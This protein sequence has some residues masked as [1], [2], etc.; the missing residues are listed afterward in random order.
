MSKKIYQFAVIALFSLIFFLA[1]PVFAADDAVKDVRFLSL[2]DIHF[3]PFIA[4]HTEN[5]SPCPLIQKLQQAPASKWADIFATY[6]ATHPEHRQDSN[7]SLFKSALV[8]ARQAADQEQARFVIILGDFLGH[9]FGTYYKKYAS[10]K[11]SAGKHAFIEKTMQ[12]ISLEINNTFHGM[13]IYPVVGNN[14]SYTGDYSSIVNGEFFHNTAEDWSDF[15]KS[16]KN[17]AAFLQQFPKAGYYSVTLSQQ[18]NLRFIFMNTVLFSS[19]ARG[20]GVD[21]AAQQ[22]LAWL[23]DELNAAHQNKQKVYIAMHIPPG[24]DVYTTLKT[25]LL[26]LVQFWKPEYVERYE[27]LL[28]QHADDVYA[29]FSG[30]LHSDWFQVLTFSDSEAEIPVTG[31]PSISPLFGNNPG[32]K[33]YS[34]SPTTLRL[35]DFVTYYYPIDRSASWGMEYDFN[36]I[37]QPNCQDCPAVRGMQ[38]LQRSGGLSDFFKLFYSTGTTSQPIATQW[39]PYYWCAI[40]NT[41]E[42]TYKKCLGE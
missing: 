13:D 38:L 39:D 34:Y 11:T 5:T 4:C 35:M 36:R 26:T 29:V 20:K 17:R 37:F 12:F 23:E 15:I 42:L 9:D 31:T 1:K 41:T 21:A 14:D 8:A 19:K 16:S 40:H 33:I 32:F 18:P 30:H 6:D 2:A 28:R 24:I 25:R 10:D 7:I 3:D 22:Q 27:G